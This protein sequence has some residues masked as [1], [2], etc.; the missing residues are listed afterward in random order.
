[1][2]TQNEIDFLRDAVSGVCGASF[3]GLKVRVE[4]GPG[5]HV[6]EAGGEI[7]LRA[8]LSEEQALSIPDYIDHY[9]DVL[10]VVTI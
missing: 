5:V 6:E 7:L 2:F 4:E 8:P 3:E 1:M 10:K 9:D